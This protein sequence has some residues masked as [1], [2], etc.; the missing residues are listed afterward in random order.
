M[1]K[2]RASGADSDPE[3]SNAEE[4]P[5][6]RARVDDDGMEEEETEEQ[7]EFEAKY[8]DKVRASIEAK[9]KLQGRIAELGIIQSL[10]MHQF[11][12]H[13]RLSF[14]FGP[15]INFIIGHN[16][17]GKSA[18][19]SAITI[20]L[21]GKAITTGRG[22]G[23]K[24]FIREGQSSSEVTVSI[25]NEGDD[26]FK[27]D[28]YGKSII[29]TRK[30]TKEG[31]SSY[32]IK[33]KEGRTVSS[34]R[35]ELSAICDHMNIQ[36]DNPMNVLSQDSA[37]QFLSASHPSDKYEF[38]LKGT[39]LKQLSEEYEACLENI[40][41]TYKILETKKEVLPDLKKA[42]ADATARYKGAKR[43]IETKA[44]AG[45]LKQELAWS[46]VQGKEDEM[47]AKIEETAK[48][49]RKIPKIQESLDGANATFD[50]ANQNI[51][52]L[53]NEL[54]DLGDIDNLDNQKTELNG[55][56][57]ANK[58]TI[59]GFQSDMNKMN[60]D[61]KA[62]NK[63]I[64]DFKAQI[65]VETKKLQE[66][67]QAVREERQRRIDAVKK[68]AED[69]DTLLRQLNDQIRG[70]EAQ[71]EDLKKK[72]AETE[73][74]GNDANGEME[75]CANQIDQIARQANDRIAAFGNN[76]PQMLH[77]IEGM[78]WH[79]RKPLGPLGRFVSLRDQRWADLMRSTLGGMMT[80]FAVTD[81]RDR[82]ALKQLLVEFKNPNIQIVVAEEDLFDYSS[83]E[84]PETVLT[85]LRALEFKNEYVKRI[86]IN[87]SRIERTYLSVTR[88]EGE[89][90]AESMG[91]GTAWSA[92]FM[93]VIV[94]ND[95]GYY[96][97]P[98]QKLNTQDQRMR[99]FA[100]ENPEVEKRQWQEKG[101]RADFV[102]RE[103]QAELAG[104]RKEMGE[105]Q[106]A[107]MRLRNDQRTLNQKTFN[108]K[109]DLRAL[110]EEHDDDVPVN[111]TALEEALQ[112][113]EN[114]K[115]NTIVQFRDLEARRKGV[116]AEQPPLLQELNRIK[117]QCDEFAEKKSTLEARILGATDAR[118]KAQH[119]VE[120]YR[121]KLAEEQRKVQELD[122]A[123][124]A[125]QEEYEIWTKQAEDFCD[126]KRIDNPR[127]P[128]EI[129]RQLKSVERAL[130]E[131]QKENGATIEEMEDALND[132]VQKYRNTERDL[133]DMSNLNKVLKS[134]VV[135]RLNR[136][137]D[138]RRH[139]ALR[140]K[141]QF[142][143]HLANRAYFGK[144]LFDHEKQKLEL[145]VQTDDQ[146]ATQ[147]LN[148]DPKSLS[149]G[150][151]SFSTI[152][153]LLALWEAIG[154]PIR[155]LDEFDVFM[156][157]VNRRISMRMMIDTANTSD[158]KQYILITP[159]DMSNV[160]F[161]PSVRVHRMGDPER[162]QST[163]AL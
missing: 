163:L 104:Y 35:E 148:K 126:G 29:I 34:K 61:I 92:D 4:T 130:Q 112:E 26:A 125:L 152:C 90:L 43:A 3:L 139:I 78:K 108:L 31:S 80:S 20:A 17:S 76:L 123:T 74:K 66:D 109:Q 116:D 150:E 10:E 89:R 72:M 67:K 146:A 106:N 86:F 136:W 82:T 33:S 101:R 59:H 42:V 113:Q 79:G 120:Y 63:A 141:L 77:K 129:E 64:A 58:Q 138:F 47:K 51:Q 37:R 13:P 121:K 153:L 53:E 30:F 50:T 32:K 132:A 142:Q 8:G 73:R 22:S 36:V 160:V 115:E 100:N 105:S 2:R 52:N 24:S 41:K 151:K 16:G 81:G 103:A 6:K 57:K 133:K 156:D 44:K 93:R 70:H 127:K 159:Q 118:V 48:T 114:S 5:S 128:A 18:V 124:Q 94:Y 12:C 27:P 110:R 71:Q 107:I 14:T 162:G 158:S 134:S 95:G 147:G 119:E 85:V 137:H 60:A 111:I 69:H 157:A 54:A 149:G 45:E 145:K 9:T 98:L 46:H 135:Y 88:V 117:A 68:E 154:C 55:K 23:L 161:G 96:S 15:Q 102:L 40:G 75:N 11:M 84:P 83:G 99:L 38:F 65:E 122:K 97:Q 140:T 87:Q 21:G 49:S 25:K 91:G 155:C 1:A 144:V 28:V 131:Q 143:Y 56:L 62:A 7:R 19:L 39:Q